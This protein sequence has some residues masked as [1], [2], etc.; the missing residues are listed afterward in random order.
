M[1]KEVTAGNIRL[2]GSGLNNNTELMQSPEDD[3]I[4][5]LNDETFGGE[6]EDAEWE[7]DQG[8]YE[9][10]PYDDFESD[11]KYG[12]YTRG[13]PSKG[14]MNMG[15][16]YANWPPLGA[17]EEIADDELEKTVEKLI[18]DDD[19]TGGRGINFSTP[20]RKSAGLND[21]LLAMSPQGL[22]SMDELLTGQHVW[23]SPLATNIEDRM[24]QEAELKTLLHIMNAKSMLNRGGASIARGVHTLDDIEREMMMPGQN[25]SGDARES[26]LSHP[27]ITPAPQPLTVEELE[28]Q[29][30][31]GD[32]NRPHLTQPNMPPHLM[33]S[34]HP[35]MPRPGLIPIRPEMRLTSNGEP[36]HIRPGMGFPPGHPGHMQHPANMVMRP[37][38]GPRGPM[39]MSSSPIAIGRPM[40]AMRLPGPD[41]AN[42]QRM[43]AMS[44]GQA[45]Q[46]LQSAFRGNM[47]AR[48]PP[49][50]ALLQMHH[51]HLMQQRAGLPPGVPMLI[52]PF[53]PRNPLT[54]HLLSRMPPP[55]LGGPGFPPGFLPMGGMV[56]NG[57]YDEYAGLMTQREKDWIVK[58]QLM[59]LTSDNPYIDDFYYTLWLLKK[60]TKEAQ[61]EE[62][63]A[64][65]GSKDS[66]QEPKLVLP[67]ISR[68]ETKTYQPAQ[69]QGALGKLTASSVHNPRQI[70]DVRPAD[71]T[72]SDDHK[73]KELRR[74]KTLL[75]DVEKGF[76][77]LLEIDELEKKA[78]AIPEA[79]RQP[80]MAQRQ[81]CIGS[82]TSLLLSRAANHDSLI[83]VLTLRKGFRLLSRSLPLLN[84]SDGKT[85]IN[86]LYSNVVALCTR[87][88]WHEEVKSQFCEGV[89]HV[90][91]SLDFHSVVL[92]SAKLSEG[93]VLHDGLSNV[94]VS[95]L[96]WLLIK[97]AGTIYASSS[98]VDLADE[99]TTT[100]KVFILHLAVT[101][102]KLES[103]S[104][105]RPC[106]QY[107]SVLA[108]L[109]QLLPIELYSELESKLSILFSTAGKSR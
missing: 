20:R 32:K 9:D 6:L 39:Q 31:M 36:L 19:D 58:L 102:Q 50:L 75:K 93:N 34:Q 87:R 64:E 18:V 76:D 25:G 14:G 11:D 90:I 67:Q 107:A 61:A 15:D 70:L 46:M 40:P 26:L 81:R 72:D 69:F 5:V 77:L 41:I 105:A 63:A 47:P 103:T 71:L 94:L 30:L 22:L 12:E 73:T 84:E 98:P 56:N 10:Y 38:T 21:S 42:L 4:D 33:H 54:R 27:D 53:D 96:V 2:F 97:Q 89:S 35:M 28:R 92:L 60:M 101:V 59:Q 49:H 85:V 108:H 1:A 99:D 74:Y 109:K 79:T 8:K 23:G 16:Y 65:L 91:G 86:G 52:P 44:R 82:L 62:E 78:L 13:F 24:K 7:E 83:P 17:D 106:G 88:D 29:M 68:V 37:P 3:D 104:L 51:Q 95:A 80:L 66:R 48:P 57:V 43:P 55:M 45:L 100:W